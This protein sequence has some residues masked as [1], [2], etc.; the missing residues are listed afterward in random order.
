METT[1]S[2]LHPLWAFGL[3]IALSF[4]LGWWMF[5][6]L[7]PPSDRVGRGLDVLPMVLCRLLGR[8]VPARMDWKQY[9]ITMLAFHAALFVL[10]F[11]LLYTQQHLPLNPDG[12][13][14]LGSLGY[15]DA[16]GVDHPGADTGVVFNTV[17]SFVTN[18]NL[19]H[20]AGEQHLS[21]FS[22]LG[23]IVWL[24]FVTPAAGLCVM[25]AVIRGLRGDQHLGDFYV[26]LMRSLVHVFVPLAVIVALL[27]MAN[28][29]PMTFQRA[30]KAT[31]LEGAEQT[32][33]R[34]PVAALVAI[35]QLGTN[36]GG[37][38]GANSTHPFENP[39]P[40]SNLISIV[41]I[42]LLPMASLVLFGLMLRDRAHAAVVYGV[43]LTFLIVG[44]VIAVLMEVRPSAA[45]D[46]LPVARGPN[47]EGKEVRLGAIAGATWAAMTTATSNGSVNSMHDSLNPLAGLVALSNLMLN[48]VFS[49][50]GAGFL[51]MLMYILVAVFI[52]GLMVGRTPEYLGKK[53]EAKEVKLAM[54]AILFH[55]LLILSGAGLFAAIAW[56]QATVA[57]PGPHG[58]SE[59]LYEFSS[60]AANNG[61]GFE[62]LAD[63]NPPW[64]VAIGIVLLL[65]RFPALIFPLAIAGFLSVKKRVPQTA[66][67]LRTD[68]LTFAG[69]LLG[70]VLL[71]GALSF[72]PALVLGPVADHLT[73]IQ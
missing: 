40:W 46:G 7:D 4:P 35:K 51:N 43:M 68:N 31:T 63:N 1:P 69:M 44:V 71:V 28:G 21:Y 50:I 6:S 48:V 60:A 3:P 72:L 62:G 2:W 14:S 19:Q 29:I 15:K 16:A 23:G 45:T 20:Y 22:Q 64:N 17:C 73:A 47:M 24:Q 37:F 57:N 41:A 30:A 70:T 25:L 59:L 9:A 32:I 38:F 12:K 67:T 39:T 61:S 18:T 13:G 42:V 36:G 65:G 5:R 33:A 66:G 52:A 8:R 54:L 11:S 27:L 49:G 10:T 55:P 26:D 53:V 34:G 56:G 58:F